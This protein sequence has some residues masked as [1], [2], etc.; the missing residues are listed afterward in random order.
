[1]PTQQGL[2][3]YAFSFEVPYQST[4]ASFVVNKP[5]YICNWTSPPVSN[6]VVESV[7]GLEADCSQHRT[8]E[9]RITLKGNGTGKVTNNFFTVGEYTGS[10]DCTKSSLA[11]VTCTY[12]SSRGCASLTFDAVPDNGVSISSWSGFPN[13]NY[14]ASDP[15]TIGTCF[16]YTDLKITFTSP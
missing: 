4:L 8:Y 7:T 14:T 5:Y 9:T 1:M 13:A 15:I 6:N 12:T 16:G 3:D 10:S 11:E 2:D